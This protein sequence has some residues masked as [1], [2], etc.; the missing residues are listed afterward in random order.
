LRRIHARGPIR[1][2]DTFVEANAAAPKTEWT[3]RDVSTPAFLGRRE[4]EVPLSELVPYIDWTF[5]FTAWQLKGVY[6]QIFEH[7]KYG[8]PARELYG[9][10]QKLLSRIVEERSLSARGVYGFW[11]A[12]SDG[13]D[14]VIFEDESRA[15]EKLRLPMLRQQRHK[16][17]GEAALS[18]SDFVAPRASGLRDYVGAFAVTAGIGAS[19]L[20][21]TFEAEHDDY[22]AIM[23]KALA[24]RLAEAFAE[25]L[26]EEAR[27]V[28]YAPSES[29]T[30]EE[31]VA[32]KYRGIR[33]AF[34]YPACPD[35]TEKGPLFRLLGATEIGMGLT[36]SFAMTPAAS[37]SGIY[38][39]HPS[40]RY[41]SIGKIGKDQ[42]VDY[43]KRK[44]MS[45]AE[46]ER[47]LSPVLGYDPSV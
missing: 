26:H 35:H 33:P 43:A 5:F 20:A 21:A 32:E 10:A 15:T 39:G 45:V 40:A 22:H 41:F 42:V 1:P 16:G 24:D 7:P 8:A 38:L 13:N 28:W 19:D 47:W 12:C 31:L 36:E 44:N 2:L 46:I 4:I 11:P 3:E 14:V 18:L 37:V 6:P 30:N 9:E 23:V 34:G 25:R 29:L 17:E 27:H